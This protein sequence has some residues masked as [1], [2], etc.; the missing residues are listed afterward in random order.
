MNDSEKR[1]PNPWKLLWVWVIG[2]FVLLIGAWTWLI[3][4]AWDNAPEAIP[5]QGKVDSK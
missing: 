1:K 3:V 4:T 2:A 5:L